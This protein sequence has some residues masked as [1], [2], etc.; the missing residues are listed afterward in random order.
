MDF[1]YLNVGAIAIVINFKCLILPLFL[2]PI[3]YE[4]ILEARH[5]TSSVD[6][7][8]QTS[9]LLIFNTKAVCIL[10]AVKFGLSVLLSVVCIRKLGLIP[11]NAVSHCII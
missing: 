10:Q 9:Q 2:F 3:K 6:G 8:V 5:I 11:L 7:L 4:F 1:T